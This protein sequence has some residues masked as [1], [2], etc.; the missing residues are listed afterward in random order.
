MLILSW[1]RFFSYFLV[2]NT[3]SKLTITLGRMIKEAFGFL[4]VV[5]AYMMLATTVFATLFRNVDSED[6]FKTLPFAFRTLFDFT[7]GNIESLDMGNFQTSYSILYIIH[8]IISNIFLIN[9]LIAIISSV[10][11]VMYKNGDFYSVQFQ[12]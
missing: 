11:E 2:L 12:Y 9:F 10:Y 6:N 8:V 5:S 4:I 3:V 7:I 1:L